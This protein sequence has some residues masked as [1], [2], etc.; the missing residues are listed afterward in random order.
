MQKIPAAAEPGQACEHSNAGHRRFSHGQAVAYGR[1]LSNCADANVRQGLPKA[2]LA[3]CRSLMLTAVLAPAL[4]YA[5][6]V[7][8]PPPL[9]KDSAANKREVPAFKH[10]F[11][12]VLENKSYSGVIGN[13]QA[14]YLN[15]LAETY[16][17]ATKYYGIRRPSLPNYIALTAGDTHGIV[18]NCETCSLAQEN[19][20]DQLEKAG[21]SW[22]AYMEDMPAPCFEGGQSGQYMRKHNPFIY[23]DSVRKD[24]QRCNKIVPFTQFA[25]DL[26]ASAVPDF[27]WIT[28]NMCNDAH[29]CTLAAADLWLRN[30][31]P[32]ILETSAWK[33]DGVLFITFDEGDFPPPN[34]DGA[35]GPGGHV[36]TV[37]A[38][39]LGKNH[40]RSKQVYNHYSLLRTIEDAWGL[41]ALAKAQ[42]AKA[43]SDFFTTPGKVR[44]A[45]TPARR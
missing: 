33:N 24:P 15:K 14:P 32:R 28:P 21:R 38:S 34:Y 31:V 37:I 2:L 8:K 43:M 12:I 41:P 23:F 5:A 25:A 16:S 6:P 10:I 17:L 42:Q 7:D 19:I 9:L 36:V 11:I 30:W 1:L 39:P 35:D 4:N 22:K 44:Q 13:S 40:Y 20:V 26:H 29:D 3:A 27:V 18:D 45:Q